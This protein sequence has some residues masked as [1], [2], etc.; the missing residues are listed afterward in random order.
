MAGLFLPAILTGAVFV[1]R[2]F[3][4]PGIG[5]ALLQAIALRDYALVSACVVLG[6]AMTTIGSL[7]ADLAGAWLDPRMRT[8]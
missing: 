4:W 8:T 2:I 3:G 7:F 6:S 5:S 1:E